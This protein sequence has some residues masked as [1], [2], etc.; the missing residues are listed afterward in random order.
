MLYHPLSNI[1]QYNN[2][3]NISKKY[4]VVFNVVAH[5]NFVGLS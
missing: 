1:S 2:I 3:C 4:F 5:R